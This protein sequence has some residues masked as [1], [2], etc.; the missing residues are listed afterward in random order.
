MNILITG[1]TGLIGQN[2]IKKLG[3]VFFITVLTRNK[4]KDLSN[5]HPNIKMVTELTLPLIEE[6][7]VVIN[8]AG[9]PI[10]EKRWT[11]KQK[12]IICKSRWTL[13]QHL[14]SLIKKAKQ[15]PTL[16]ISGS[17]IGIYG[18]QASTPIS[19]D[20]TDF[21]IEFTQQVCAPWEEIALQAQSDDTRVAILRTGIVL[22][23]KRGALAKMILPF[24]IG[25]GGKIG[26]GE[27]VM[28]WI[29]ID[30]MV[31]AIIHIMNNTSLS[32]PINL[33]SEKAVSNKNF[34]AVLA[35]ELHRPCLMTTPSFV[36]KVIFGE[37]ADILLFGQNVIP[38]KLLN[39]GFIFQYSTLE[40]ALRNIIHFRDNY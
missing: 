12:N 28:S 13:T 38:A 16:F 24:K 19:E 7:D 34:S 20:F 35:H 33:T 29:H 40:S 10:A 21:N 14:S 22:D 26:N 8:L 11:T 9:E 4:N 39:S 3:S 17:A 31:Q 18:R 37:M 1:G 27:Q 6:Q 15:K 32:G 23:A 2:L 25:L 30:D 5:L 36:V